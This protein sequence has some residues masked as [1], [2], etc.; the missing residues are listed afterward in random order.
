MI[1][2]ITL[3]LLLFCMV[4]SCGKKGDPEYKAKIKNF[5]VDKT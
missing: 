1:K 3:A 5:I 4:V 2:K